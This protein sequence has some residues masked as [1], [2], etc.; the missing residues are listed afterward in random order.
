MRIIH[1]LLTCRYENKMY[2]ITIKQKD[3]AFVFSVFIFYVFHIYI[4]LSILQCFHRRKQTG[5]WQH[6]AEWAAGHTRTPTPNT[7]QDSLIHQF[8]IRTHLQRTDQKTIHTVRHCRSNDITSFFPFPLR[9]LIH[10]YACS[11]LIRKQ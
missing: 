5:I 1:L 4:N 11:L 6:N 2:S 7:T 9:A 10:D 8:Y 3:S